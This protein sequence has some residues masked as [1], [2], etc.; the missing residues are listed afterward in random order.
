MPLDDVLPFEEFQQLS[1][2]EQREKLAD[3]RQRYKTK[4]IRDFWNMDPN[5]F[6]KLL[7]ELNVPT[8]PRASTSSWELPKPVATK[9]SD[10]PRYRG[11]LS[12]L[13]AARAE[14]AENSSADAVDEIATAAVTPKP[15][16]Q[17][18]QRNIEISIEG[19][20]E[21]RELSSKLD[22]I[23]KMLDGLSNRYFIRLQLQERS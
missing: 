2:E 11:G 18:G 13:K 12:A 7:H 5:V 16:R 14:Q 8:R 23:S 1:K 19:E 20:Y 21:G 15:I 3:W 9:L 17:F 22:G 6:Y 10:L 4:D